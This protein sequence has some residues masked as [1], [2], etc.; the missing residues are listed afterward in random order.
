[1]KEL[2]DLVASIVVDCY[3]EDECMMAFCTVLGDEIPLPCEAVL[4]GM[5]VEVVA[6]GE[7]KARGVVATCHRG[8][9]TG[10]VDLTSLTFPEGSVAAWLQAAY[11]RYLGQHPGRPSQPPGWHLGSWDQQ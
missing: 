6:V 11:L 9:E 5:P 4:L 3:D 7:G 8:Q 1:V 2:D 10:D